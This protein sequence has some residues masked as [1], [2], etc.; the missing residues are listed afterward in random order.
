MSIP[1]VRM[2]FARFFL[3]LVRRGSGSRNFLHRL[4]VMPGI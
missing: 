2:L 4:A 3:L 1:L